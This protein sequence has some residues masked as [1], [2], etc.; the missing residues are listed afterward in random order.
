[1]AM[2]LEDRVGVAGNVVLTLLDLGATI[3]DTEALRHDL[4]R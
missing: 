4:R 1:M 3:H 2:R